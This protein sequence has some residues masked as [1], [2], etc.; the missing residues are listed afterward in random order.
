MLVKD[1]IDECSGRRF[2]EDPSHLRR[3]DTKQ[4]NLLARKYGFNLSNA[5]YSGH[6]WTAIQWITSATPEFVLK[7]TDYKRAKNRE[8]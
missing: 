3:L 5:Y 6:Y 4:M 7:V 1:G 2:Y 8:S